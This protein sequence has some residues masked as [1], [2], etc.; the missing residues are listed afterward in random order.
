MN[1]YVFHGQ[2]FAH[3]TLSWEVQTGFSWKEVFSLIKEGETYMS[4]DKQ[5]LSKEW[6]FKYW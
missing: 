5:Y 1:I 4:G 2:S 3:H 6:S